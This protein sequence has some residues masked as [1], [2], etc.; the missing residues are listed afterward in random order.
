MCG[1]RVERHPEIAKADLTPDEPRRIEAAL[2]SLKRTL[3]E[4]DREAILKATEELN[5]V[6]RH[7][8]EVM[9]NRSVH[10]ALAGKNVDQI[11]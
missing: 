10:T 3:P 6:T 11:G 9:M 8:A 4:T 1:L 5:H 7:L 2:A